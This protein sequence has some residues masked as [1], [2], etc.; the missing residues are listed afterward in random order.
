MTT[1]TFNENRQFGVEIEFRGDRY[2]VAQELT[3]LGIKCAVE[4]YNHNTRGYWKL[5][6]DASAEYEIVSPILKGRDGLEQLKKVC[7]ALNTAGA[8]VDKSCG[9]H[10]HHD[11]NDYDITAMK[12]LFATYA[13]FEE[14][15]DTFV[16]QSRRKDNNR[17]CRSIATITCN[18]GL[19][20][21][22]HALKK[23]KTMRELE[24]LMD[25][26][27]CKLNFRSYLKYGTIEFRQHNGTTNYEKMYNW[28][29]LTQHMVD[30]AKVR[31]INFKPM[32][33]DDK[34]FCFTAVM[35]LSKAAGASEEL[36]NMIKWFKNRAAELAS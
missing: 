14:V 28:I 19:H 32:D 15:I 12:N 24:Y 8:T 30:N 6:T 31:K 29:L 35:N 36:V 4:D 33:R 13:K 21:A 17:Y 34:F 23:V 2:T 25:D 10:V 27:Y 11:V 18:L 16:P 22:L 5:I 3:R 9:V 1:K 20:C 26:R 7:E